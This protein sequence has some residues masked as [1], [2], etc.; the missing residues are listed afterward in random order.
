MPEI[1]GGGSGIGEVPFEKVTVAAGEVKTGALYIGIDGLL[2]TGSGTQTLSD[3][4]KV[5]AAGY[6]AATTLDAVDGDLVTGSIK[7]GIT[8]FGVAGSADVRD[9]GDADLVEAEAPTGKFFYAVS[10]GRRTGTGTKTL[11]AANEN[12]AAGYYAVT[13]LSAVDVDL[14]TGSIKS[15]ITLFG[16]GGHTDVRDVSDADLVVAEAPT[17]KTFYAVGGARKTGTGTKTLNAA[18]QNVEAGYYAAT[19]LVTVD[20]DFVAAKIKKDV[21]IFGVTGTFESILAE[22]LVA[23]GLPGNEDFTGG[24]WSRYAEGVDATTYVTKATSNENY[25]TSSIAVGSLFFYGEANLASALKIRLYMGG[26][27]VA[28]SAFVTQAVS[29]MVLVATRALSGAQDVEGGIYNVSG[30]SKFFYVYAESGASRPTPFAVAT[31][32]VKS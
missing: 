26:V 15:G 16:V 21:V 4:S 19:T 12:V 32:S 13:T 1:K 23:T 20:A 11:S 18:N 24:S 31:G 17:G 27:M 6:Y 22:D 30:A 9:I 3:G 8:L 10:G 25:A 7:S 14:V 29:T 28:E 2:L 5:V